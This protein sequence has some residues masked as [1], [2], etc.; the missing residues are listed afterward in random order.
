MSSAPLSSASAASAASASYDTSFL[1]PQYTATFKG[2]LF[3][4]FKDT[5][6]ESHVHALITREMTEFRKKMGRK[7]LSIS[8]HIAVVFFEKQSGAQEVITTRMVID[9]EESRLQDCLYADCEHI[10][11]GHIFKP[12]RFI[13]Q[14]IHFELLHLIEHGVPETSEQL[15]DLFIEA[16]TQ[17]IRTAQDRR[18]RIQAFGKFFQKALRVE[19]F[20]RYVDRL[21][22]A[23]GQLFALM[24]EE[25]QEDV[26]YALWKLDDSPETHGSDHGRG[27]FVSDPLH[28][29]AIFAATLAAKRPR[30]CA[31]REEE[32]LREQYEN[33]LHLAR[34]LKNSRRPVSELL[35]YQ[36]FELGF[37]LQPEDALPLLTLFDQVM[38]VPSKL[39]FLEQLKQQQ[40]L[41]TL[42]QARLL[43]LQEPLNPPCMRLIRHVQH[44]R[45]VTM[46]SMDIPPLRSKV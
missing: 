36:A 7:T 2:E 31:K 20:D 4:L 8:P 1:Y 22:E 43:F 24:P 34:A 32:T 35:V 9:D 28:P 21:K 30:Y 10:F 12:A 44:Q 41:D 42:E 33:C 15:L 6:G 27:L 11:S 26:K 46:S 14:D 23:I 29:H 3:K 5:V 16:G 38:L 19:P 39:H 40:G 37:R 45:L 18:L 17:F 25:F 13:H